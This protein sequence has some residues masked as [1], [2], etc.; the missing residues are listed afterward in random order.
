MGAEVGATTSVFPYSENM[1]KYL[2]ATRRGP[3]ADA[4]EWAAKHGFLKADEGVEYDEVIE[5][6][7]QVF[8]FEP[9]FHTHARFSM[10]TCLSWNQLSMV[11]SRQIWRRLYPSLVDLSLRMDGRTN[12]Q[13]ASSGH[14]RIARTRIWKAPTSHG[15]SIHLTPLRGQSRVA[16]I[17]RQAKAAGLK[18]K[19]TSR[20][21][22][23]AIIL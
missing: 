19:V 20:Y 14:V 1:G 17:A 4:A 2:R 22:E 3:V 8:S 12:Y 6:V 10:R 13:Q 11:H 5:I 15:T 16:S 23:D 18:A 9:P 7:S 21:H